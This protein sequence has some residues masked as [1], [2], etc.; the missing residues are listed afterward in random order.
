[1][2]ILKRIMLILQADSRKEWN[3]TTTWNL[4]LSLTPYPSQCGCRND[5]GG[6]G[7]GNDRGGGD[8]CVVGDGGDDGGI[9]DGGDGLVSHQWKYFLETDITATSGRC[10]QHY[11]YSLHLNHLSHDCSDHRQSFLVY[12]KQD[13][14]AG[15][16]FQH[17]LPI[18]YHDDHCLNFLLLY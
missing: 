6:S 18:S 8:D 2:H 13:D 10:Q 15:L 9:G 12:R 17:L 11:Y 3:T 4:D 16:N 7:G 14:L 1:M 5:D